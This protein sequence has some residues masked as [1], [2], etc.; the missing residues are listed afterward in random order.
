MLTNIS[1]LEH[2]P[3]L[4]ATAQTKDGHRAFILRGAPGSE[5]FEKDFY[6]FDGNNHVGSMAFVANEIKEMFA[7]GELTLLRGSIPDKE[8]PV[9][10]LKVVP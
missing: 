9:A 6:I 5:Y 4:E 10:V 2:S 1:E 8:N 3:D 7:S